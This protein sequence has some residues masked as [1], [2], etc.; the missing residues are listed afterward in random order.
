MRSTQR[1][2]MFRKLWVLGWWGLRGRSNLPLGTEAI[3]SPPIPSHSDSE[4]LQVKSPQTL[5]SKMNWGNAYQS[6]QW[7]WH[8]SSLTG[9][10]DCAAHR[11]L[12]PQSL[13]SMPCSN[14]PGEAHK[15]EREGGQP[16]KWDLMLG[17]AGRER[18]SRN[19]GWG[20]HHSWKGEA[21][22]WILTVCWLLI[23]APHCLIKRH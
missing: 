12:R 22:G 10:Q 18:S 9:D 2:W 21:K 3:P 15:G 11:D 1:V 4:D 8:G 14:A 19:T 17:N 13:H 23:L 7:Q 6:Q 16:L 20:N 5:N